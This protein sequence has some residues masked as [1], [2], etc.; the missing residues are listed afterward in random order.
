VSKYESYFN[1]LWTKVHEILGDYRGPF[2]VSNAV[3]Q[4]SIAC[5]FPKIFG[6]KSQSRQN[7]Q[8]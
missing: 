7:D 3:P 4:L 6:I 2:V 8:K 5:F 1:R